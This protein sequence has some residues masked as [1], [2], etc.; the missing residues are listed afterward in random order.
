MDRNSNWT[1]HVQL[2]R[3]KRKSKIRQRWVFT[4]TKMINQS[5]L[6]QN[7]KSIALVPKI[8]NWP[9]ISNW[10][11]SRFKVAGGRLRARRRFAAITGSDFRIESYPLLASS[12]HVGA[13]EAFTI[14]LLSFLLFE[15]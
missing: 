1:R 5:Q 3:A 12:Q 2:C 7:E 11:K 14:L 15:Q 6:Y 4:S 13:T 9:K 8:F 10:P